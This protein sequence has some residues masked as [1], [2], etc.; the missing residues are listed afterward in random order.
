M[1]TIRRAEDADLVGILGVHKSAFGGRQ[2]E[3]IAELVVGL[4]ADESAIPL[5]S[6]V[7]EVQGAIV[8]HVLFTSVRVQGASRSVSAQIL[9]PLGVS[10]LHQGRG[11]GQLL[12]SEG[13][14]RLAE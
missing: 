2:G 1:V 12:V 3:E 7:A 14:A 4:L 5:F 13:L 10:R 6:F 8:G 9:A 11:I